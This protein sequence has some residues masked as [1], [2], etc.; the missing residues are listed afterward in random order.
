MKLRN[1]VIAL[2]T[3]LF[4]TGIS[5][6]TNAQEW[7]YYRH[8]SRSG[9]FCKEDN[10]YRGGKYNYK[11][12]RRGCNFGWR[13]DFY[14]HCFDNNCCKEGKE[15]KECKEGKDGKYAHTV[16]ECD[17]DGRGYY[18]YY[19][20]NNRYYYD[21]YYDDNYRPQVDNNK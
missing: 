18:H 7:R 19:D 14:A 3:L 13:R 11:P 8:Y 1:L 6:H 16:K 20:G 5:T 9:T 21:H 15:G 4:S 12:F 2:L 17:R 10:E